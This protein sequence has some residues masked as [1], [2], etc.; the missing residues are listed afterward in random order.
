MV[1]TEST[2]FVAQF[3]FAEIPSGYRLVMTPMSFQYLVNDRETASPVWELVRGHKLTMLFNAVGKLTETRGFE[4]VDTAIIADGVS[5]SADSPSM[6]LDR[7]PLGAEERANWD[8]RILL[9]ASQPC[10]VGTHLEFDS[11]ERGFTGERVRSHTSMQVLRTRTCG[12]RQC[13]VTRY[14]MVPDLTA[15]RQRVN[16]V[17]NVDVIDA[18]ASETLEQVIESHTMLPH[19]ERLAWK[20]ATA[21]AAADEENRLREASLVVVSEF[22]YG[23]GSTKKK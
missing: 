6:H 13:V 5:F 15:V 1:R 7:F 11:S 14:T 23:A 22:K 10:A 12:T 18:T 19:Y 20:M 3:D 4:D 2:V 16:D 8:E 9:W 17:T 21:Q